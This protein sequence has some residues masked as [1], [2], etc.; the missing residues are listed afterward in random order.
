MMQVSLNQVIRLGAGFVR[1]ECVAV[2]KAGDVFTSHFGGGVSHINPDGQR[3]DYLGPGEPTVSTNGFSITP[4]GDFLCA[5]LLPPGGVWRVTRAGEQI[6]YLLELDGVVLDSVNFV[7]VDSSGRS[8]ISISTQE[9]PRHLGYRGDIAS[10][11]VIL[12][13]KRGPRV[14]AEDIGYTNEVKVDPSGKW[15]CVNET[16]GRKTSRFPIADDG[17]LGAKQVIAEYGTGNYPDGMEFDE[18]GGVWISSIISN[19]V[20]RIAPDGTQEVILEE[21]DEGHVARS[22]DAYLQGKLGREHLDN[23]AT[24]TLKNVSSITF[25]GPDLKTAYVGN[26]LDDCIYTFTSPIA[27]APPPHWLQTF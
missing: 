15:L 1:P 4:E 9:S 14:V 8:W 3:F 20:I 23:I 25:G 13:D 7:H 21:V 19:R 11:Y 6:P 5:S 22:E 2:T 17:S 26:L 27:G 12:V 18:S 10:G 16:F 24:P